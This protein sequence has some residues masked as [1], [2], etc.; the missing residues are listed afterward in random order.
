MNKLGEVVAAIFDKLKDLFSVFEFSFFFSGGACVLAFVYLG[1]RLG[2]V[3]QLPFTPGHLGADG[4]SDAAVALAWSASLVIYLFASY[5]A[6]LAA[7]AVGRNIRRWIVGPWGGLFG[8]KDDLA[9]AIKKIVQFHGLDRHERYRIY[10]TEARVR[11]PLAPP[12][13]DLEPKK[14]ESLGYLY[15]RLWAEIRQ[16]DKLQTS[17]N[18][19][20]S[21]WLR[22]AV[23]DGLVVATVLWVGVITFVRHADLETTGTSY[24][25]AATV[26]SPADGATT[27]EGAAEPID[28]RVPAT[29]EELTISFQDGRPAASP[30]ETEAAVDSAGNPKES[31]KAAV[32][33]KSSD[34]PRD[35]PA[36]TKKREDEAE[37]AGTDEG[38]CTPGAIGVTGLIWVAGLFLIAMF[39]WESRKTSVNQLTEVAATVAWICHVQ[40]QQADGDSKVSS[41]GEPKDGK[42]DGD[43]PPPTPSAGIS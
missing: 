3:E 14:M 19:I 33:D 23:Y 30:A 34:T 15:P 5:L 11:P 31:E 6:G 29:T 8:G 13:E 36:L 21:F 27:H 39:M 38:D 25:D 16:A 42:G 41:R 35:S 28:I 4:A 20:T 22:A 37:P 17:V 9:A 2:N 32:E 12:Q 24:D 43:V 26:V 18:H 40:A 1:L 10:F 7:F